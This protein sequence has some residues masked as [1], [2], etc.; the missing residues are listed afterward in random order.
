MDV[1]TDIIQGFGVPKYNP[2]CINALWPGKLKKKN[3]GSLFLRSFLQKIREIL[4]NAVLTPQ[5]SLIFFFEK[6][7]EESGEKG[8]KHVA[9]VC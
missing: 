1:P 6:T 8:K 4:L 2:S 7:E 5:E 3:F 9:H